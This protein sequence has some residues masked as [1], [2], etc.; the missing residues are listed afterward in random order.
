MSSR[1]P[2]LAKLT[3][4]RQARAVSR[5]RLFKLLDGARATRPAICVVGPPG[6]GKT[7]LVASWLDA[8]RINGIWYQVD[9]GDSDLATFFYYLGRAMPPSIRTGQPLLPLLTPEYLSDLSTFSRRFFRELFS[10]MPRNTILVLDNYHDIEAGQPFHQIVA[11][12]VEEVAPTLTLIVITRQNLPDCYARLIA[13]DKVAF[14]RWG[15]LR[16]TLSEATAIAH[17]R[18]LA[19]DTTLSMVHRSTGGWA[20]GLVLALESLKQGR[21]AE[22]PEEAASESSFGYFAS[23]IFDRLPGETQRFLLK[24]ACLPHIPPSIAVPLTGNADATMILED[25]YRRSLFVDKR[26]GNEPSY[27]YHPLFHA[28]LQARAAASLTK[29]ELEALTSHAATLLDGNRDVESAVRL[30]CQAHR[31]SDA[32]RL[33][34]E[35]APRLLSQ[36]RWRTFDE[37]ISWLPS[38]RSERSPWLDYWIGISRLPLEPAAAR[39]RLERAYRQ[40]SEAGEGAGA[41]LA[42]AGVS[43]AIQLEGANFFQIDRWA[44]LL[45]RLIVAAPT[46]ASPRAELAAYSGMLAA[47]TLR[48][49]AHTLAQQCVDRILALLTEPIDV[50]QRLA[51]ASGLML[52]CC[53]MGKFTTAWQLT[54]L[55]EPLLASPGLTPL[56]TATWYLYRAY[57]S[58]CEH[59]PSEG[60]EAFA[61]TEAI[62]EERNFTYVLIVSYTMR[63]RLLRCADPRAAETL[64]EKA[65]VLCKSAR[66]HDQAHYLGTRANWSADRGDYQKAVEY[67][68]EVIAYVERTGVLFQQLIYRKSYAWALAEVGRL[69]DAQACIDEAKRLISQT[70]AVCLS[71][72]FTLCEANLARC[73]GDQQR[74]MALLADAFASARGNIAA[75]RFLYWAPVESARRLCADALRYEIEV[76]FVQGIIRAYPLTPELPAPENWPWPVKVR[77]LGHLE[78]LVD[79]APPGFSR[80]TPRKTLSLLASIIAFG[81]QNVPEERLID[82]LWPDEEGD[83]GHR[84]LASTLHRLR[85]L[86]G[87]HQAIEQ[88][89]GKLSLNPARCW[90]DAFVFQRLAEDPTPAALDATLALYRGAFLADQDEVPWAIPMRERLRATFVAAVASRGRDLEQAGDASTALRCYLRGLEADDLAEPLYQGLMRCYDRLDRRPEALSAYQRLTRVLSIKLGGRPSSASQR[91]YQSLR[92]P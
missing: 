19:D 15:E 13:N 27:R 80:K 21:L 14:V 91:L 28:F 47:L 12:A 77:T 71:A 43:Q 35:Q 18:G 89:G 63:S 66:P 92:S 10:R 84:L 30:Y 37:W 54:A 62:A 4:A 56:V 32:E 61:R 81:G 44:P 23:Q 11:E 60:L 57:L 73:S 64:I 76:E 68:R 79:G 29:G 85:E 24:S 52:Y 22:N 2:Q 67:G 69:E 88:R 78:L 86:L 87:V 26:P 90:V 58:V 65:G 38:E 9:A 41:L 40:F 75:G 50:N 39:E 33:I 49:P 8:R 5:R 74:Y 7:T 72:L 34:V 25:L 16:L 3:R 55:V 42:A 51:A 1:A 20:A 59:R 53:C 70:E 83:A 46:F 48:A 31:W 82:A 17:A 6:A 45:E 36:G